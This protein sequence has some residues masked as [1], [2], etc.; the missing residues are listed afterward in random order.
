[1]SLHSKP[2]TDPILEYA[3]TIWSPIISNINIKKLQTIQ[4]TTLHNVTGCTRETNTQ[5]LHDKTN[6]FPTGT[7]F[8][9]H[10]TKFKQLTQHKHTLSNDAHS[11]SP[12]NIKATIFHNNNYT[13]IIISDPDIT[14]EKCK[15]NV[16]HIH[17][18]ITSQYLSSKKITSRQNAYTL[19]RAK[20]QH[21]Q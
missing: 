19:T 12:G 18:T 14:P 3:N 13:N 5:H 7:H 15:E 9:L 2:S 17:T 6:F 20:Y 10:A 8:K 16:K 1:M 21:S 11:D 4:S